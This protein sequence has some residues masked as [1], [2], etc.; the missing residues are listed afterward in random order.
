MTTLAL[1]TPSAAAFGIAEPV[2]G[3]GTYQLGRSTRPV[4]PGAGKGA[5]PALLQVEP[6]SQRRETVG[7]LSAGALCPG[8][9]EG[10]TE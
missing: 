8:H 3:M 6:L 10:L 9:I 7:N 4:M 2:H 1:P 5:R